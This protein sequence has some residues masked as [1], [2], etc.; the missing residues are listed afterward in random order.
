MTSEEFRNNPLLLRSH[1]PGQG[2]F[3]LPLIRKSN[4]DLKN[5]QLLGYDKL[6]NNQY[7]KIVHFFLD[8]YKFE[9]IWNN[10]D[11]R[12]KRLSKYKAVLSPQFSVYAEMPLCVKI[13]Q[14]FKNRWCGAYLQS[15]GLKVI[16]SLAWGEPDTYW[17]CF[18]GI[19]RGSVVA[20]STVGVR[21][22]KDLFLSGYKEMLRKINPS[23]IICYGKAFDE[24]NG[25]IVSVD[26]ASTNNYKS[27]NLHYVHKTYFYEDFFRKGMG[28]SGS[29]INSAGISEFP[30]KVRT[31]YRNYQKNGWKGTYNGQTPGTKAGKK[32]KNE[33]QKLPMKD[34][35]GNPLSYRE[36]DINDKV[37]GQDRG[38]ERFVVDNNGKV[39]YTP[40]HYDNFIEIKGE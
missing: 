32:Y 17:F 37:P 4:I 2:F 27:S 20:V 12:I 19:E 38:S 26:Y 36:F 24:M 6:S 22:E 16:P 29:S 15:K 3:Q 33:P 31:A 18:D 1:F 35:N 34:K 40:D 30:E 28:G 8:D 7:E 21:K 25:N 9:A 5:I 11:D 10:P 39:Y 14:T 23:A 13:H